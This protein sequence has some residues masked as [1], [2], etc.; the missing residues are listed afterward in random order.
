VR[1]ALPAGTA[2]SAGPREVAALVAATRVR[3]A[4][5]LL[6]PDIACVQVPVAHRGVTIVDEAFV[7]TAHRHGLQVHVWTINE[8]AQMRRLLDLGVDAL[9]TDEARLLR[10]VLAEVRA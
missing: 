4:A 3:A 2:T 8:E 5:R 6:P 10:D 7:A 1:R 9:V